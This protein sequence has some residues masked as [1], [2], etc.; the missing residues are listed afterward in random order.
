MEFSSTIKS[1]ESTV[2]NLYGF[3]L[4]SPAQLG[5]ELAKRGNFLP[6]TESGKALS[7][8]ESVLAGISDP[9]AKLGMAYRAT[10]KLDSTYIVPYIGENRAYTHFRMD[11]STSRLASYKRNLQNVPPLLRDIFQPDNGMFTWIDMSQVEMRVFAHLSQDPVLLKAYENGED[12]H[13][14]TQSSLWPGSKRDDDNIRRSAKVFNFSMICDATA[15][16][17][18]QNTG[19]P[20]AKCTTYRNQWLKLY[21]GGA[22]WMASQRELRSSSV[23]SLYAR[24]LRLPPAD[25]RFSSKHIDTCKINY[26]VQNGAAEIAKRAIL[27]LWEGGYCDGETFRLPIHDELLFDGEVNLPL[28]DLTEIHPD[29]PTPWDMKQ[30]KKWMK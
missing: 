13:W 15:K 22:K 16:T 7:T 6:L 19:L 10:K 18:S 11:L 1:F 23:A 26:P 5:L 12:V 8:S 27:S 29:I 14:I 9:L 20:L 17:I 25:G 4:G 2:E 21:S 3:N 24:K 30:G 28:R